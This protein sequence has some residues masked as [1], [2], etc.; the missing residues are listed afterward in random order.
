M[1]RPANSPKRRL[2]LQLSGLGWLY[3]LAMAGVTFLAYHSQVNGMFWALGLMVGALLVCLI[4]P[5]LMLHRITAERLLPSHAV[6]GETLAVRYELSNASRFVPAFALV[7][8]EMWGKGPD[9][10]RQSGPVAE[11]PQRLKGRPETWVLHLGPRQ[12]LQAEAISWPLRRGHLRFER[13]TVSTA[14]PF[15]L[16]IGRLEIEQTTAVL[17]FPRLYRLRRRMLVGISDSDPRSQF[18]VQAAGDSEEFYGMREYRPGDNLRMI[19]WRRSARTGRLVAREMTQPSPPKVMLLLDL[20]QGHGSAS[21]DGHRAESLP[22]E[23]VERAISLAASV[24]CDAYLYGHQ[25]GLTVQGV[26]CTPFA[27]HHSLPHR[28]KMLE[29]LAQLDVSAATPPAAKPPP[30]TPSVVVRL[31]ERGRGP[32]NPRSQLTLYA[33]R[34]DQYVVARSGA[35]TAI[36]S[37]RPAPRTNGAALSSKDPSWN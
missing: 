10:W 36:L 31:D 6:A 9:H 14:F 19:D 3:L 8:S 18:R 17:V 24:I 22:S 12:Q 20:T 21:R 29:A 34:I 15:N 37:G 26:A 7:V 23:S 30:T 33:D 5:P 1:N 35:A 27:V 11:W 28:T 2:R 25:V 32:G 13:I 16:I 4:L